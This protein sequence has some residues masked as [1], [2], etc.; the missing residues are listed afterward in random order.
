VAKPVVDGIERALEGRASVYRLN[1]S[2]G[3]AVEV[4]GYYGIRGLP[5][6]LVFDGQGQPVLRQVGR[7]Q[8]D[9]ILS[10]VAA[11]ETSI[12]D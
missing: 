12:V 10:A 7:M 5:T 9:A 4:A 11:I 6:L 2:S 1:L 3:E 8:K